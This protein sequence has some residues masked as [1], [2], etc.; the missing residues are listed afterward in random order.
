MP[1]MHGFQIFLN[2]KNFFS[3]L[4]LCR[5]IFAEH[6]CIFVYLFIFKVSLSFDLTSL[7]TCGSILQGH[8]RRRAEEGSRRGKSS[9]DTAVGR[10]CGEE[11]RGRNNSSSAQQQDQ[12]GKCERYMIQRPVQGHCN[13]SCLQC[14]LP[15]A[16]KVCDVSG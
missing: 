16:R 9:V 2:P 4:H 10:V 6:W 13:S 5:K 14:S 3:Q 11:D 7:W 15:W 12:R 1:C 8:R